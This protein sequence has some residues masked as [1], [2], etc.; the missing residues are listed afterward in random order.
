M[1]G[2]PSVVVNGDF[3]HG[4]TGWRVVSGNAFAKQPVDAGG[5]APTRSRST[6]GTAVSLGGDFWHTTA[7]RSARTRPT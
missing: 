5:S 1:A 3:E 4:L 6:D 2:R 7:I